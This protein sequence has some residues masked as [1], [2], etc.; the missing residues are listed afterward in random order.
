MGSKKE[1]II[2]NISS[3]DRMIEIINSMRAPLVSV[4]EDKQSWV[5]TLTVTAINEN[6]ICNYVYKSSGSMDVTADR[7]LFKNNLKVEEIL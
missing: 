6:G 7:E 3:A 1:L 5:T 2:R 4:R